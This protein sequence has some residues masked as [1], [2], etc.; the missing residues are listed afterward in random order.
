MAAVCFLTVALI[1]KLNLVTHYGLNGIIAATLFGYLSTVGVLFMTVFRKAIFTL[2]C[3]RL[4]RWKI[5]LCQL[6]D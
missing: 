1:L 5:R 4:K 2:R 3:K 6:L